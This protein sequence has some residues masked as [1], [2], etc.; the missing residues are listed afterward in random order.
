MKLHQ[1]SR[2]LNNM[3]NVIKAITSYFIQVGREY[4]SMLKKT[5]KAI[6]QKLISRDYD[7]QNDLIDICWGWV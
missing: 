3:L 5:K 6:F 1:K 2:N 4:E 7:H